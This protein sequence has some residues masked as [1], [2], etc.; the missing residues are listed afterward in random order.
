MGRKGAEL[1]LASRYGENSELARVTALRRMDAA[2]FTGFLKETARLL[3]SVYSRSDYSG[4]EKLTEKK[5]IIAERAASYA[6]ESEG[7]SASAYRSFDM[8]GINN[9]YL[10]LYRLYEDDPSLYERL[11][12]EKAQGSLKSL[13]GY[14]IAAAQDYKALQRTK[15][16]PPRMADYLATSP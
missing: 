4:E 3:E 11:L 10:D 5:R 2:R 14:A 12:E 9:A 15:L 16:A 13:I 6:G 7:Y 1:Y 8:G